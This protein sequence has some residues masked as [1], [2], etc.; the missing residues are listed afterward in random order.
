[1][2]LGKWLLIGNRG[3]PWPPGT[4]GAALT[5]YQLSTRH[6]SKKKKRN[7]KRNKKT[8]AKNQKSK[9]QII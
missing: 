2:R 7:K 3:E 5:Q 4:C 9:K 1:M 8:K 6:I